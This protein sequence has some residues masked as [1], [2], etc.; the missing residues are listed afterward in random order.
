MQLKR[1][2]WVKASQQQAEDAAIAAAGAQGQ[3]A[4]TS[5]A[6]SKEAAR[7]KKIF[8][9]QMAT[10]QQR[11]AAAGSTRSAKPVHRSTTHQHKPVGLLAQA[12][13]SAAEVARAAAKERLRLDVVDAYRQSKSKRMGGDAATAGGA[14]MASLAKLVKRAGAAAA[15]I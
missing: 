2:H 14:S 1:K 15:G 7:I 11:L 12:R 6:N 3:V 5:A 13:A 8:L 10:A 9:S 4:A